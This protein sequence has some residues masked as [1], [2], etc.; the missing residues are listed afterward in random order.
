MVEPSFFRT[1]SG[2]SSKPAR[3][4]NIQPVVVAVVVVALLALGV[5]AVN[6]DWGGPDIPLEGS[7]PADHAGGA[8]PGGTDQQAGGGGDEAAP[9]P[10]EAEINQAGHVPDQPRE[11]AQTPD[12]A[13]AALVDKFGAAEKLMADKK[14]IEA[15]ALYNEI[16]DQGLPPEQNN[17]VVGRLSELA[18]ITLFSF[19]HIPGDAIT[20]LYT[21]PPGGAFW[22]IAK[23]YRIRPQLLME[24]NRIDDAKKL[25]AGQK[26]KVVKGPFN[27]VVDKSDFTLSVY[28]DLP[29]GDGRP[30]RPLLVRRYTVGLGEFNSTPTG[31][32]KI[33]SMDKNPMYTH[34]RTGEHMGPEHAEYPF[35]KLG[36]WIALEGEFGNALGQT[37]YGIHSTNEPDSIAKQESL[38]CVRMR[39]A[40]IGEL[41]KLLRIADKPGG[42]G[43]QAPPHSK[44]TIRE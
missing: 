14:F 41:W 1:G 35:G 6:K 10:T 27:A 36:L 40:D 25:R 28:I 7:R 42:E 39:D 44:V 33:T 12:S 3:R 23:T 21:V 2:G 16:V 29:N 20:E 15:R 22:V 32:W 11:A 8:T 4:R 26:I 9:E 43:E 24:I 37:G 38:G 13:K 17:R 5:W 18:D 31:V 19:R 34:P 30:H